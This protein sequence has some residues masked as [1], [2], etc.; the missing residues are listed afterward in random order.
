M[1]GRTELIGG[2]GVKAFYRITISSSMTYLHWDGDRARLLQSMLLIRCLPEVYIEMT[3]GICQMH[4]AAY[5][6]KQT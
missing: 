3:M 4:Q 2:C 6:L 5:G 1:K